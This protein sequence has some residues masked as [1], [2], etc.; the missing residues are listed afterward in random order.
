MK[1]AQELIEERLVEAS[2]SFVLVWKNEK[3]AEN[4]VWPSSVEGAKK[5]R[6][7]IKKQKPG[8]SAFRLFKLTP[9]ELKK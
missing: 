4:V 5:L 8:T 7:K 3:G 9:V 1:T 6:D 2:D